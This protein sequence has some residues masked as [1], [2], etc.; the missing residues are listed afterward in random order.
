MFLDKI[1]T[2]KIDILGRCDIHGDNAL[3]DSLSYNP[4]SKA[5]SDF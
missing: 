5:V 2:Y 3:N 4:Q 1:K